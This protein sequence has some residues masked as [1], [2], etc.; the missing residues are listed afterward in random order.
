MTPCVGGRCSLE[1]AQYST[2]LTPERHQ[3]RGD[4]RRL[5]EGIRDKLSRGLGK[6]G[7]A[8][9]ENKTSSSWEVTAFASC[10]PSS[11]VCGKRK[12]IN[13]GCEKSQVTPCRGC[14]IYSRT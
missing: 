14:N 7:S 12:L 11:E 10:D 8:Q 4:M 9:A 3:N 1:V 13:L 5:A 6:A 2:V